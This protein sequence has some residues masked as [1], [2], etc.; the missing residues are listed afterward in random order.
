MGSAF[1]ELLAKVGPSAGAPANGYSPPPN[2]P[3]PGADWVQPQPAGPMPGSYAA[4]A[5]GQHQAQPQPSGQYSVPA[6]PLYVGG[7]QQPAYQQQQQQQQGGDS[8]QQGCGNLV[9]ILVSIAKQLFG[10]RQS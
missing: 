4:A 1:P 7:P 3:I 8:T 6:Q 10:R 9:S 5:A 2:Q